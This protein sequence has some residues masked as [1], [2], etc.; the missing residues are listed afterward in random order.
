MRAAA[1]VAVWL[2][3]IAATAVVITAPPVAAG[4]L[5]DEEVSQTITIEIEDDGDARFTITERHYL[6]SSDDRDAFQQLIDEFEEGE[7]DL[8]G[9]DYPTVVS[10]VSDNTDRE[11]ALVDA[12]RSGTIEN[13]NGTL[14]YSFTWTQFALPTDEGLEVGDAFH[15]DDDTH[16]LGSL[17]PTQQLVIIPPE[18]YLIASSSGTA[19]EVDNGTLIWEGPTNFAANDIEATFGTANESTL[20]RELLAVGGL[21]LVGG[22]V[23]LSWRYRDQLV[24][25]LDNDDDSDAVPTTDA[26]AESDGG[27]SPEQSTSEDPDPQPNPELLSDPE[28]V[29]WLLEQNGGRLKQRTIVDETDWSSAKVSQLLSQM[30]DDNRI[31]KLRIGRENLIALPEEDITESEL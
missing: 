6:D 7:Y 23:L 3:A 14:E 8:G 22:V 19:S 21:L 9:P 30:E 17:S 16:W 31:Q 27:T 13:D 11:M 10:D 15:L 4:G 26:V 5:A 20:D 25:L 24:E 18:E 28:R 2:L 29:E 12:E 1:V